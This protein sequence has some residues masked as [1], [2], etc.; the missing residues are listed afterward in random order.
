MMEFSRDELYSGTWK[1]WV[2]KVEVCY[3]TCPQ[4]K[5]NQV[6]D[7]FTLD[8]FFVLMKQGKYIV[9]K[10]KVLYAYCN[11]YTNLLK[12]PKNKTPN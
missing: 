8:Q 10:Y 12:D 2:Q 5:C 3:D 11:I 9:I 7:L 4:E 6:E 1:F